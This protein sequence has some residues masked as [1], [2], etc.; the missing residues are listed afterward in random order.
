M[1][2]ID[3]G[4]SANQLWKESGSA[5]SFK[6]WLQREK[7][8]GRFLPNKQLIEFNSVEGNEDLSL[9][10]QLI[11]QALDKNKPKDIVKPTAFGLSKSII[12][13]SVILVLGGVAYKIYQKNSK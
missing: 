12:Y 13:L 7:D 2:N 11:K 8:K 4:K 5:L 1:E 10:Q 3:L 6:S 9:N